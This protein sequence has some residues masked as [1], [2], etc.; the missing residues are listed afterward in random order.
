M[1]K[2]YYYIISNIGVSEIVLNNYGLFVRTQSYSICTRHPTSTP[3]A[4]IG[5]LKICDRNPKT[6]NVH[7]D[8]R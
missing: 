8:M 3:P 1:N 4:L 5:M 7:A 6:P 2:I